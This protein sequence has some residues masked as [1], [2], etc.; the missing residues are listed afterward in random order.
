VRKQTGRTHV[1]G[2]MGEY[3]TKDDIRSWAREHFLMVILHV[4]P[5]PIY[6]LRDEVFPR[7]RA[8]FKAEKTRLRSVD[9]VKQHSVRA[10]INVVLA[11]RLDGFKSSPDY[12][13]ARE[14]SSLFHEA[15]DKLVAWSKLFNLTGKQSDTGEAT[16][17]ATLQT[18]RM[19]S[20]WPLVAGLE[21]ILCWH[22]SRAGIVETLAGLPLWRPKP[23]KA[24]SEPEILPPIKL[25]TIRYDP[26]SGISPEILT[27]LDPNGP[28]LKDPVEVDT[29]GWHVSLEPEPHFRDRALRDFKRWLDGYVARQGESAVEAGF[30][31][32]PGKRDL[33]RFAWAVKY[34]VEEAPTSELAKLYGVSKEAV[35]EGI[36]WVLDV[37]RLEPR[38][39]RRGP[40]RGA[41]P[42]GN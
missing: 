12:K 7:Y 31:P 32:G 25:T 26:R 21:T 8:A 10:L 16:D 24:V 28:P 13:M 11:D 1:P 35:T 29:P 2:L 3:A 14:S 9:Q 37:I 30:V 19:D 42:D 33:A 15:A 36:N 17:T 38:T 6:S 20:I 40:K 41:R 22:L 27:K 5:A 39:G 4:A 23:F 18:A 34:Q